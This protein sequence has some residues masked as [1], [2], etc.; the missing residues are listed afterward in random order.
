GE[1]RL[2]RGAGVVHEIA[3]TLGDQD[4]V[5]LA[6]RGL[7]DSVEVVVGERE[8][9]AE[10]EGGGGGV[11]VGSDFDGHGGGILP[12]ISERPTVRRALTVA[13]REALLGVGMMGEDGEGAVELLGQDN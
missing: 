2:Q 6:W 4:F 9:D 8:G 5:N 13:T 12:C 3:K 10:F 7:F 11:C 1:G